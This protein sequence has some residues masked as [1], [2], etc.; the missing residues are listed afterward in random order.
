ML[1][2][3]FAP[4]QRAPALLVAVRPPRSATAGPAPLLAA[5]A[6]AHASPTGRIGGGARLVV[7][8]FFF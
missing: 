3:H 2:A 7:R 4:L 5:A 6:R 8:V 1:A